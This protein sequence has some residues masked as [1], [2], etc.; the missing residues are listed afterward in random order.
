MF[1]K[2]YHRAAVA[3]LSRLNAAPVRSRPFST[4]GHQAVDRLKGALEQYRVKK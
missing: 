3:Q 2:F 1:S 4:E